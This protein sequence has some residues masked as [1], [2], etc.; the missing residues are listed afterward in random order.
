MNSVNFPTGRKTLPIRFVTP[1]QHECF[2]S[3]YI[4]NFWE[5]WYYNGSPQI[6]T[7]NVRPYTCRDGSNLWA[8]SLYFGGGF[9][10]A[11]A[12]WRW[13]YPAV[14]PLVSV[15]VGGPWIPNVAGWHAPLAQ[16]VALLRWSPV[17][18]SLTEPVFGRGLMLKLHLDR[19]PGWGRSC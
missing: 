19:V 9:T 2:C 3:L 17:R 6:R 4:Y 14:D 8:W 1:T 18:F 5:F 12:L 16:R 13:F 11:L 15:S 10:L 7:K